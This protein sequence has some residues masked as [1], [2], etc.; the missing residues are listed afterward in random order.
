MHATRHYAGWRA[1]CDSKLANVLF[2]RELARR[3]A[4][5]GI[6]V[7]C[8]H[9]GFVRTDFFR[10]PGLRWGLIGVGARVLAISPEAGAATTIY[11]A[12]SPEV[13]GQTGLYFDRCRPG[14]P[15]RRALDDDAAARLWDASAAMTGLAR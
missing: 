8:L 13:A 10:K 14:T 6:T 3:S 2:T 4:G 15:S 7:N 9:P 11:L 1:Y 12:S 5:V